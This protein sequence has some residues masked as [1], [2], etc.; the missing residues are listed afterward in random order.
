[1]TLL[2]HPFLAAK[3]DVITFENEFVNLDELLL[4][5]KQGICFYPKLATLQPLLT[6]ETTNASFYRI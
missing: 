5:E 2:R 6:T 3:C 4:L 1:M